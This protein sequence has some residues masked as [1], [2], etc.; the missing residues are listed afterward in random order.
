MHTLSRCELKMKTRTSGL[1]SILIASLLVIPSA[2]QQ[3]KSQKDNN[4]PQ[5][6]YL[7]SAK[8]RNLRREISAGDLYDPGLDRLRA[9]AD[10][11][12]KQATL[13]VM[14][15]GVAPP[16]G[17]KHDYLSLAPYWWP[18]PAKPNGLPYIRRDG[19]VN[20]EIQQVQD[21]KNLDRVF[22]ATHTLALAYYFL[23]EEKYAARAAEILRAWFLNPQTRMNP[24]LAFGQGI[25][26]VN[27]GRGTGLIETRG[28]YRLVDAIGLLAG[29]KAWTAADQQGMQD[30]CA[31]Y[32]DWMLTSANGKDEA[33][34]KNNHG[35]YY[36][37]QI[38][39][40]ALFVGNTDLARQ[41]IGAVPHK[42]I[43]A[44]IEPD[45]RQPLELARTKSL[46]YSTMNLAG[47]FELALLAENVGVDLWSFQ[48]SDGRSIHKALD[49]L[50]PFVSGRE[51]WPYEQIVEYHPHEISP[52]LVIGSAKF[53]DP[54]Y[55][56]LAV[57]IDP[58]VL[59]RIE[60]FP[61]HVQAPR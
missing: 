23:G 57:K 61:F 32:L 37:V 3:K 13:S 25:R 30:W 7:P 29:S 21:H 50:L 40:L 6:F 47:H 42:R 38:A 24:N 31:R 60:V 5:V 35:T 12:L 28:I 1:L 49:Y 51:K 46:G 8:L 20:P 15:K 43:E 14:D 22:A 39:S 58:D 41:I 59:S 34:A 44:Q 10:T 2:A 48:S 56:Q 45:G 53:K 26:G 17:D 33:A 27:A 16:S 36:D 11:A 54:S 52:L 18:D 55:Q 19:E 9:D 4:G